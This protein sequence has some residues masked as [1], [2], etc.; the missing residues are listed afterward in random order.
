DRAIKLGEQFGRELDP[1]WVP[2]RDTIA[3]DVLKNGWNDE[4]QSF[5]T[6]YDGDDLDA[7]SL[8]VGLSGLIDPADE[9][10]QSTVTAIEAELRSGSTVYR[11]HRD[12][13][14]P[15]DEGGF[16]LCAA[17]MIE[18]YLLTGRRTEAEELF[19]QIV[20]AAGPTGLL[21]EEYDPVAERSLG[22]HP[23]AYS[24]LGLIRCAQ[25]LSE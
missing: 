22:N 15:G 2:L 13:G 21:P 20:A 5:T 7:A 23:Q 19:G 3:T 6:A 17:W 11:Y 1:S 16:H 9:R 8:F 12:D 25:L 18:A 4:V 24:H 14:L 10:F